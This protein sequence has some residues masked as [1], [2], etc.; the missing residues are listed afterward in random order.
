[1]KGMIK[2]LGDGIWEP[3]F[4]EPYSIVGIFLGGDVQRCLKSCDYYL[5]TAL[6]VTAGKTPPTEVRGNGNIV[7]IMPDWVFIGDMF[8]ENTNPV[9][10]SM[11]A[12]LNVLRYWKSIVSAWIRRNREAPPVNP[13]EFECDDLPPQK[14]VEAV[15]REFRLAVAEIQERRKRAVE[16]GGKFEVIRGHHRDYL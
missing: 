7:R 9:V 13:P 4:E 14:S 3:V 10:I 11:D 15:L 5:Y 16:E 1:M 8:S 2:E 12:F 6:D